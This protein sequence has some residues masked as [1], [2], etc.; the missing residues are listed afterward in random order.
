M[1]HSLSAFHILWNYEK[2]FLSFKFKYTTKYWIDTICAYRPIQ[3]SRHHT[4]LGMLGLL[5]DP[6][7]GCLHFA[8]PF[9]L[10][11]R[12]VNIDWTLN[13]NHSRRGWLVVPKLMTQIDSN[14]WCE[15]IWKYKC[16]AAW[17][18]NVN[19]CNWQCIYWSICKSSCF[20]CCCF[21]AYG[22]WVHNPKFGLKWQILHLKP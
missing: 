4:A 10:Y 17:A 13:L 11:T 19:K 8:M 22:G 18:K 5:P 15:N 2:F 14:Q 21:A 1:S 16:K 20:F 9:I 3:V 6:N 7:V 12:F